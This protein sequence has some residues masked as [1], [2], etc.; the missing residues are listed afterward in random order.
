MRCLFQA[1]LPRSKTRIPRLV[2][3]ATALALAGGLAIDLGTAAKAD[4]QL[5]AKCSIDVTTQAGFPGFGEVTQVTPLEVDLTELNADGSGKVTGVVPEGAVTF[6]V[7]KKEKTVSTKRKKG[8]RKTKFKPN[9]KAKSGVKV[10]A[11]KPR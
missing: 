7:D 9:K 5:G 10:K 11:S 2:V 6:D 1:F 3:S 4:C 8:E